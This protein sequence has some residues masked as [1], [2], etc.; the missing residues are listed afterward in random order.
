MRDSIKDNQSIAQNQSTVKVLSHTYT[1]RKEPGTRHIIGYDTEYNTNSLGD[2]PDL[3]SIQLSCKSFTNEGLKTLDTSKELFHHEIK[4][5]AKT[6]PLYSH[7]RYFSQQAQK[8]KYKPTC[9]NLI[10]VYFI[11]FFL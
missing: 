7:T 2:L 6:Q 3:I 4:P 1:R 8:I 11:G 5:V 10:Y 9:Y